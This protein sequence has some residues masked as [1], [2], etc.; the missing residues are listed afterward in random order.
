MRACT[1]CCMHHPGDP[2]EI[3]CY[4]RD[5][6]AAREALDALEAEQRAATARAKDRAEQKS[7]TLTEHFTSESKTN[8]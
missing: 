5:V 6:K 8:E 3:H 7:K 2:P 1:I 4:K